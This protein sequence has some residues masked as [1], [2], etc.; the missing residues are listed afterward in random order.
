MGD[1][2][3]KN[4]DRKDITNPVHGL[5]STANYTHYCHNCGIHFYNVDGCYNCRTDIYVEDLRK[6]EC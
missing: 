1:K 6:R 4:I 5:V 3:Q 2:K